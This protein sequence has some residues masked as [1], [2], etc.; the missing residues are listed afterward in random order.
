MGGASLAAAQ[1][2]WLLRAALCFCQRT[3]TDM[4]QGKG[5]T[6]FILAIIL[7]QGSLAQSFEENRKLN[8]Y[9]QEDGSV[10]LTC[11]VKSTNITWFKEGKMIDIL[12]AHK[13]KWN[14][15]SNTKDPRGVYQCKGSKD[16]SKTLQVYYRMCQNCIELNAATILG[17]VF[18]EIIS[19]FF[20]AVGVYFIAGQDGV[21]QSRASDKQTL[22]PNDQLYQPLKDREDDQYSHLQ[23]NQLRRN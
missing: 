13:N 16:K 23:G 15:G 8:V 1:A 19:I 20:L 4:E 17:F 12:T 11:H 5:L 14:L 6:G 10:L 2:G 22:L 21:R 18:A 9:N 7:L 3:E